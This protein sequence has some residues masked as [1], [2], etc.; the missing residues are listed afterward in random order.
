VFRVAIAVS[1]AEVRIE[2]EL[3]D[4]TPPRGRLTAEQ[5]VQV[6]FSGWLGLLRVLEQALASAELA[7]Q[8]ASDQLEPR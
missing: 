2:I 1:L 5:R 4:V 3:D 6:T 8:G 7:A